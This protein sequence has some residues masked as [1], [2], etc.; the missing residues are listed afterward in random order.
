MNLEK[1]IWLSS[2]ELKALEDGACTCSRSCNSVEGMGVG[3]VTASSLC[4]EVV[5]PVNVTN[6]WSNRTGEK[7][8]DTLCT[9]ASAIEILMTTWPTEREGVGYTVSF[10]VDGE[11][12]VLR[13]HDTVDGRRCVYRGHALE[14]VKRSGVLFP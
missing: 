2:R 9:G 7:I 4:Y 14:V 6:I 13:S 11:C 10:S 1:M 5:A 8:S 12:P 3:G